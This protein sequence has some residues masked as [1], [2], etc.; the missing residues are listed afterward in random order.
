M[1]PNPDSRIEYALRNQVVDLPA[2]A[3]TKGVSGLL[4]SSSARD[5]MRITLHH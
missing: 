5:I 3:V 2:V 1:N 4:S